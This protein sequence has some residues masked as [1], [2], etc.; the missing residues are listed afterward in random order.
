MLIDVF[1]GLRL[2]AGGADAGPSAPK[3]RQLLGLL[4]LRA[5]TTV[6]VETC[7]RELWDDLPPRSCATTLQTY[8]MHLRRVLARAGVPAVVETCR[9]GYRLL[10]DPALTDLGVVRELAR[11]G[12]EHA[13]AGHAARAARRWREAL[14]LWRGPVLA[15]VRTGPVTT[16]IVE[17]LH[18][19]GLLL[20]DRYLEAELRCGRHRQVVPAATALAGRHPLREPIHASLMAALHRSGRQADAVLVYQRLAG[21]LRHELGVEPS[22]AVQR[23]HRAVRAGAG[24]WLEPPEEHAS[25]VVRHRHVVSAPSPGAS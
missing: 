1:G 5:G 8:V 24:P 4:V 15:D 11:Q 23:L 25:L 12:D 9:R 2:G 6:T 17:H 10:A 3:Q 19:W 14:A 22:A 16:D 18:Q 21:A 20:V 13:G 7:V